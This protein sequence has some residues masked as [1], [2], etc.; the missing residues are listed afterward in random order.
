VT[1]ASKGIRV[2]ARERRA[3]LSPQVEDMWAR[4]IAANSI[5]RT[6]KISEHFVRDM[7]HARWPD[8][9]VRDR[10]YA[11]GILR[12]PNV[13][14]SEPMLETLKSLVRSNLYNQDEIAEVLAK[15]YDT[16]VNAGQV[17]YQLSRLRSIGAKG[18]KLHNPWKG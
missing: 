14:W 6:L 18:L 13:E 2:G 8:K 4:G 15:D 9:K 10:V 1:K 11:L 7:L 12:T 3:E 17:H 5:S 16:E